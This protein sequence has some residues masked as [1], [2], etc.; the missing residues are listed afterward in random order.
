MII[1]RNSPIPQYFQLQT[2]LIEQIEQGIFRPDDK[3]PTEEEI[4]K[5]TGLA[6][7]TIRQAIQNLVNAGYLIRKRRL[8]TFVLKPAADPDRKNI[9]AVL[10]HD[11]RSG[12][13]SEFLRGAG[14]EAAK[15][16]Y[17]VI[18]C[19]TDDLHVRADF[20]ANQIINY[21]I[22]GLVY[23]PTAA[24]VEK[25]ISIVERFQR[26]NIP[27]ILAD[28]EISGYDLDIVT[29]DNFDG[30]YALSTFLINKGH[31]RI[32]ITLS[33]Q[34]S[35]ENARL[36]G[37]HKALADHN[38]EV[39]PS[40]IFT[41]KERL[42]EAQCEQY[43]QI[44]LGQRD[45]YTAIFAGND[46]IAYIIYR[47]SR[48]LNISIPDQLSLVGYDDLPV[49]SAHMTALTTIH[50]PI[51]EMGQETIKL[52]VKRIA[53]ENGKSLRIELKS[54]LVDRGSVLVQS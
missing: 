8:G 53:G 54:H 18:L 16:G 41:F 39:D 43:A 35:S 11:I 19:N 7:A 51:Y 42:I 14:D 17:S 52:L 37:Y 24:S 36:A 13:A 48:E 21:G 32:A 27:V 29:T 44:I 47:I 5:Q 23:M 22:A 50:Q 4:T 31:R 10:V 12:Y 46:H 6:R 30:A 28:R 40:I 9:I 1:D 15:N 33:T 45:N 3:I 25:N 49:S 38:I 20:H 2:W 34:F 26:K